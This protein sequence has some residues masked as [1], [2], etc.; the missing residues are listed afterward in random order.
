MVKEEDTVRP[1]RAWMKQEHPLK[2][3]DA[4]Q[5]IHNTV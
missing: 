2:F 5:H 1:T 3:E 4:T